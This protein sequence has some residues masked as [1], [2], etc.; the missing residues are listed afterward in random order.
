MAHRRLAH[1]DAEVSKTKTTMSIAITRAPTSTE[2]EIM[3]AHLFAVDVDR[4]KRIDDA[5]DYF[6]TSPQPAYRSSVRSI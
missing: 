5:I 3:R 4:K 6:G 1:V 2:I